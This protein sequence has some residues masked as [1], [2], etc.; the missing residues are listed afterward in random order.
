MPPEEKSGQPESK[1]GEQ[2]NLETPATTD[3]GLPEG[4]RFKGKSQKEIADAHGELEKKQGELAQ[5]F[6]KQKTELESYKSWYQS[7]QQA[8]Q[9]AKEQEAQRQ[10]PE[11][12]LYKEERKI[13]QEEMQKAVN[14]IRFESTMKMAP[15]ARD[16]AIQNFPHLFEDG[17]EKEVTDLMMNSVRQGVI[18]P[19]VIANPDSWV[20]A[21]NELRGRK[22]GYKLDQTPST[23][24]PSPTEVPNATKPHI[25]NEA[26]TI[27]IDAYGDRMLRGLGGEEGKDL[28]SK[29]KIIE[30]MQEDRAEEG[31]Q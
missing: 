8:A 11:D 26:P 3:D 20:T 25:T 1:P 19:D 6:E 15:F 18:N 24:T 28:P 12:D 5:E 27:N 17:I 13:A 16:K 22:T 4:H 7:A 10:T 9:Q 14:Q 30:K 29:E 2:G 31:G 23:M 21:A